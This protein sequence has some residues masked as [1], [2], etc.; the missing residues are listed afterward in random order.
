MN[1]QCQHIIFRPEC[2]HVIRKTSDIDRNLISRNHTEYIIFQ[3]VKIHINIHLQ[4]LKCLRLIPII[5][6]LSETHTAYNRTRTVH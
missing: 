1:Q 2:R 4:C 5:P 3:A 6:Y